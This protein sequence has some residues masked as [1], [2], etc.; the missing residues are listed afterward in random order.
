M[1]RLKFSALSKLT[2][3]CAAVVLGGCATLSKQECKTADWQAIGYNDGTLGRDMGYITE[4]NKSCGKIQV[5]PDKTQWEIGRQKG[6]QRYCTTQI[7]YALGTNNRSVNNVCPSEMNAELQQHNQRGK[8]V[9]EVLTTI[10]QDKEEYKKLKD[11]FDKLSKGSNL[12][13]PN[14]QQARLYMIT[15]P[16]RLQLLQQ[17]INQNERR[18]SQLRGY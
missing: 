8:Q 12:D 9:Y 1:T 18:L 14:E 7:A 3:L 6:L 5:T 10:Q 16:A 13:F 17:K 2:L 11:Q 4:H 15:L